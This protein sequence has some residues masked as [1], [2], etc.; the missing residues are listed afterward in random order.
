M[1]IVMLKIA[2]KREQSQACLGYAKREQFGQSQNGILNTAG[3][4]SP[5][6]RCRSASLQ[7]PFSI[8]PFI[9]TDLKVRGYSPLA[10]R[11][12]DAF[13][14]QLISH[15]SLLYTPLHRGRGEQGL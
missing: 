13:S 4:S 1:H 10:S 9:S 3:L 8:L 15:R 6:T 7:T 11:L 2:N 12:S 14:S 5:R